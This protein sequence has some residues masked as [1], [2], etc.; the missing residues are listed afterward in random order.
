MKYSLSLLLIA[1]QIVADAGEQDVVQTGYHILVASSPELLAQG[2]G[3]LWD[4]TVQS[5][6]SLWVDY[7]GTPLQAN[8]RA[9]WKVQVTCEKSKGKKTVSEQTDWSDASSWGAGL[10]T[11]DN[12]RGNWIG[13][14]YA[15]PWDVEDVHS[16]LSARYYRT[17]FE[18]KDKQVRHATLHI[19][20]LGLY[21][22]FVNGHRV[23]DAPNSDSNVGQ[24]VLMPAPT[25][26]RRSTTVSMSPP[27]Y[28]LR[29]FRTSR[30]FRTPQTPRTLR[31]F[32]TFRFPRTRPTGATPL[33]A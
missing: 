12:W 6:Q 21:E 17:T 19:A 23:G 20:G 22:A 25:D 3:D 33:S 7:L 1:W 16:R 26:Y 11:G 29:T 24:Q 13:L 18:T 5:P 10:L 28:T 2:R 4:A 8:Q 27:I 32:R 30:T 31:T 14:D 9:Y 15:M